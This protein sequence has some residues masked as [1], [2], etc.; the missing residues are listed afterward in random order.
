M[1]LTDI[2]KSHKR[3]KSASKGHARNASGK[4]TTSLTESPPSSPARKSR[5]DQFRTSPK[6]V[7][8]QPPR[9]SLSGLGRGGNGSMDVDRAEKELPPPPSSS[10]TQTTSTSAPASE[11]FAVGG[12]PAGVRQAQDGLAGHDDARK[13]IS[14]SPSSTAAPVSTSPQNVA[15]NHTS[16]TNNHLSP[17]SAINP[18]SSAV[19]PP[20][21]PEPE[22]ERFS[23]SPSPSRAQFAAS[24][25]DTA[26][27]HQVELMTLAQSTNQSAA[28]YSSRGA[29]ADLSGDNTVALPAPS[30]VSPP[31]PSHFGHPST[32]PPTVASAPNPSYLSTTETPLSPAYSPTAHLAAHTALFPPSAHAHLPSASVPQLTSE[33]PSLQDQRAELFETISRDHHPRKEGLGEQVKELFRNGGLKIHDEEGKGTIDWVEHWAEPVT[34]ER[35]QPVEERVYETRVDRELNRYHIQYVQSSSFLLTPS[36]FF[37]YGTAA[38][39]PPILLVFFSPF[40]PQV[41]PITNLDPSLS[42]PAQ[43][44]HYFL[45]ADGNWREIR[46]RA[47]AEEIIRSSQAALARSQTTTSPR[48]AVFNEAGL[49]Q[50]RKTD[51]PYRWEDDRAVKREREELM[52]LAEGASYEV[53]G[54]GWEAMGANKGKSTGMRAGAE[55]RRGEEGFMERVEESLEERHARKERERRTNVEQQQSSSSSAVRR[56]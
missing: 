37:F 48:S 26:V 22:F 11:G 49:P 4:S 36:A 46:G 17:A 54:R 34:H 16:T 32:V 52:R 51:E 50:A 18:S 38:D 21:L 35:V 2:F 41:L 23:I 12:G 42:D 30:H 27:A 43:E 33:P 56:A 25:D 53:D 20:F 9:V 29:G 44:L 1:G 13:G 3:D 40:S 7:A 15:P 31:P 55:A 28:A 10:A 47:L 45:D 14:S 8:D 19:Q 39:L 6:V 24:T 5:D